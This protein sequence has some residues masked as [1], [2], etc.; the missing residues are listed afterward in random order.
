MREWVTEYSLTPLALSLVPNLTPIL[1]PTPSL[2]IPPPHSFTPLFNPTPTQLF[3][4]KVREW[5][6]RG[7]E[8]GVRGGEKER[9]REWSEREGTRVERERGQEWIER[10]G[11]EGRERDGGEWSERGDKRSESERE[12]DGAS[13]VRERGARVERDRKGRDWRE[14]EGAWRERGVSGARERGA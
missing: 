3:H 4:S 9:G 14:R 2:P 12:R 7:G 5:S 6:K 11:R 1:H 13:V 10:G 8:S